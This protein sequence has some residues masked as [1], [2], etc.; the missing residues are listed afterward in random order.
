MSETDVPAALVFPPG[1]S[2]I[3][4]EAE[5]RSATSPL[6]AAFLLG[7]LVP[8]EHVQ[9]FADMIMS[10]DVPVPVEGVP[11]DDGSRAWEWD[12]HGLFLELRCFDGGRS[13]A[14]CSAQRTGEV[15]G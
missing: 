10:G 4:F 14:H 12:A 1:G 3:A 8:T 11:G 6:A 2:R 9:R 7:M 15:D 5:A 13:D